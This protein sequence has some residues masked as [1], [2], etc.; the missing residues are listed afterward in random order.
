M[1]QLNQ[2]SDLSVMFEKF[3]IE[4][5][6]VGEQK[7]LELVE[8]NVWDKPLIFLV[9]SH[10]DLNRGDALKRIAVTYLRSMARERFG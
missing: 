9:S 8:L 2:V 1:R 10:C 6:W 3:L 7:R 4:L 5:L